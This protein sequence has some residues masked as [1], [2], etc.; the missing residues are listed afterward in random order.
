MTRA[1]GPRVSK[2]TP[3]PLGAA[4]WGRMAKS[5][6]AFSVQSNSLSSSFPT[7]PL[8]DFLLSQE[9]P[10]LA[11]EP[12]GLR[13]PRRRLTSRV[14]PWTRRGG[15]RSGGGCVVDVG[16]P[17]MEGEGWS[18]GER[19]GVQSGAPTVAPDTRGVGAGT[20]PQS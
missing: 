7:G 15:C 14:R 1:Y 9:A 10:S 20:P 2:P 12:F 13:L 16:S 19:E 18:R 5:L 11:G 3:G 17:W 6:P 4:P 8:T